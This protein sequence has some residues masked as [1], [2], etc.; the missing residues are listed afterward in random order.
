MEG[1]QEF[2]ERRKKKFD[3]Q[4]DSNVMISSKGLDVGVDKWILL[5]LVGKLI[6]N[7][8][9]ISGKISIDASTDLIKFFLSFWRSDWWMRINVLCKKTLLYNTLS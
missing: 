9:D 8:D 6:Q 2:E 3:K 7:I 5:S 4:I 1:Y